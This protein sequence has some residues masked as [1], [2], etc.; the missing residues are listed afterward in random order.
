MKASDEVN[1]P[2]IVSGS[3]KKGR[4]TKKERILEM[5]K[6][7]RGGLMDIARALDTQTSYVARVLMDHGLLEGYFDLYT[8]SDYSMNV[9]SGLF[10]KRLGFKDVETAKHSVALIDAAYQELERRGDRPGQ[11]HAQIMALTCFNRARW[12]G[13]LEE[14]A[15][16]KDWLVAHLTSDSLPET[17][18]SSTPEPSIKEEVGI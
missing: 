18:T 12:S 8:P 6:A 15:I 9:Y 10:Q 11:H 17:S 3:E 14:A 1:D 7:G 4:V 16:F 2:G 5:F 13:K